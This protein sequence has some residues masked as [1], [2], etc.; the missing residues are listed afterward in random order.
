[1]VSSSA[2]RSRRGRPDA[3]DSADDAADVPDGEPQRRRAAERRRR[4]PGESSELRRGGR[5]ATGRRAAGGRGGA[6]PGLD[7]DADP[8]SVARTVALNRLSVAPQTRAQLDAAMARKGVP[9]DVRDGVLD[10]FTD[11]GLVDDAAYA[12]AWVES[13]HAGRGLARR[14]LGYELRKR[15]VEPAVADDAVEAL[16]PEKEEATARALVAARLPSTRRLDPVA[17]TRRLTGLLARKGF[18]PG[19]AFRVVREALESDGVDGMDL[20]DDFL[21][22]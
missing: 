21:A 18:P 6:E 12:R 8:E 22:D 13:R 15:G 7:P 1:M 17:R 14:A 3:P 11:V 16:D 5:G 2:G 10:R 9:E 4:E 20:P 19:L